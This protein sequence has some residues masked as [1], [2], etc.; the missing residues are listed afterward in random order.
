MRTEEVLKKQKGQSLVETIV[1]LSVLMMGFMGLLALLTRSLAISNFVSEN[2]IA[3]YLAAEGIEVVR[4]LLDHN[5]MDPF[6]P[7]NDGF[8]NGDFEVEFK[9]DWLDVSLVSP[10]DRKLKLDTRTGLYSYSGDVSTKFVR[11][12]SIELIDP[13][14][15]KVSSVV[16]WDSS[17]GITGIPIHSEVN[18]EDRFFDPRLPSSFSG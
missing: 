7:W 15:L 8:S 2:Y 14:H 17:G 5:K 1:A 4:N 16:R 9:P 13:G 3:T 12:V 18:L 11:V 6:V 10:S